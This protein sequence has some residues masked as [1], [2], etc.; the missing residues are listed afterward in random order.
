MKLKDTV[1]KMT[2]ALLVLILFFNLI[3]LA[4]SLGQRHL[5]GC[6]WPLIAVIPAHEPYFAGYACWSPKRRMTA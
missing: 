1:K 3:T 6:R 2:T 4:L 5:R